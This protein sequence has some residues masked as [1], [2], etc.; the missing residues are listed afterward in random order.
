M[1]RTSRFKLAS[2]SMFFK[3]ML[4]FLSVIILLAAFNISSYIYLSNKL[5]NEIVRY[6]ELG[7]KQ[8]VESY[9]NHFRMTQ[10]M[11][12]SLTQSDQWI[13]NVGILSQVKENRRYDIIDEVKSELA[14]LYTNPFLHFDNLILYF[15]EAGYVLEKEGTSSMENMFTKYYYSEHYS[16]EFWSSVSTNDYLLQVFPAS[17][18]TEKTMNV[19][20]SLGTQLPIIIKAVPYKEVYCIIMMNPDKLYA[21]YAEAGNTPFYILDQYG[22][23]LFNSHPSTEARSPD[24][25]QEGKHHE[26][27]GDHYYFYEK[28]ANTGF[29]YVR[30]APTASIASELVK[31]NILLLTLLIT[32][33]LISI[34]TSVIFSW[35]LNHPLRLIIDTLEHKQADALPTSKIKEFAIISE[36]MSSMMKTNKRIQVD[37]DKKNTWVRQYAYTNKVKNIPMTLNLA[38]LEESVHVNKPYAAILY[39]INCKD[40]D[41]D[42]RQEIQLLQ[43]LIHSLYSSSVEELVTLQIEQ[44]QLMSLL[45]NPSPQSEMI[46][47]LHTLKQLLRADDFLILTIA[48]SPVHSQEIPFTSTYEQLSKLL[49]EKKLS[50]ETQILTHRG[51][52]STRA[53]FI[54]IA[55]REE[56]QT[57]LMSGKEDLVFEW[58]DKHLLQMMQMDAASEDFQAFARGVSEQAE[59]TLIRLNLLEHARAINSSSF[60]CFGRFYSIQQYKEWFRKQLRPALAAILTKTEE[61]DPITSYVTDYLYNNLREDINLDLIA[62]KLKITPGY[63]SSYFKEKTGTNFSDYLNDL[64]VS[65]AK[66]LLMN[67]EL[68]IQD[69][70]GLIGYQNVNSFIRMFKRYS[71]ITPGEYRKRNTGNSI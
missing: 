30:V 25:F 52:S 7:I 44:N 54:K 6:N 68:R 59:M 21:A 60:D 29:T 58:I 27:Y 11:I 62:D 28:G 57:R 50:G 5:Y 35:R 67:A 55:Q 31:L 51:D 12:L 8:T 39:E 19:V 14:A 2:S 1:K 18:F 70:A 22:T 33:I 36:R 17:V 53:F 40:P 24:L 71:G 13:S 42:I 63:L 15:K 9:E 47:T 43:K 4:S 3:L 64:R 37:L 38:E 49:K 20:R 65:R 61:K 56:L 48:A 66:E 45:F 10:N 32:A 16:P 46:E 23:L 69:V 41:M 26:Q 34:I